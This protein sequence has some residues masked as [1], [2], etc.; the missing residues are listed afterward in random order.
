MTSAS[1]KSFFDGEGVWECGDLW[2][3]TRQGKVCVKVL[4]RVSAPRRFEARNRKKSCKPWVRPACPAGHGAVRWR[5][6]AWLFCVAL[7]GYGC[8]RLV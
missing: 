5:S 6:G 4:A 7:K 3:T 2:N 8:N 1:R